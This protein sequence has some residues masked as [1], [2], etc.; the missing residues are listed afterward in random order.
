QVRHRDEHK[1]YR[2]EGVAR[3]VTHGHEGASYHRQVIRVGDHRVD[4][5]GDGG[6]QSHLGSINQRQ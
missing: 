3:D 4:Q 1:S 5:V 6:Q 2:A